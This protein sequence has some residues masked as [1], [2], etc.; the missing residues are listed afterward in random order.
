MVDKN[1]E[2]YVSGIISEQFKYSHEICGEKF[3]TS[4]VDVKRN[5]GVIDKVPIMVSERLE[6][7]GELLIGNGYVVDKWIGERVY[8]FG[9]FR[10][11]NKHEGERNHLI[12]YLFAQRIYLIEDTGF[13][14]NS[15][16]LNGFICKEPIYRE[17]E[18]GRKICNAMIAVN[19]PY[20]KSDY[21]P[22][23]FWGRNAVFVDSLDVGTQLEVQG[24]IQS[25]EYIKKLSDT[26]NET[27][28]AYEVS[29]SRLE[30]IDSG[31]E[32]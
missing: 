28:I 32:D 2:A 15:I 26:E 13:D 21:I 31:K 25:R 24:R 19:R 7:V 3:Y 1:N 5:S 14:D 22:C 30:V 23:I 4:V 11:F 17:L 9:Q 18:S 16:A 12:L 20:R 8:I 10:S 6:D 27:R 29:I